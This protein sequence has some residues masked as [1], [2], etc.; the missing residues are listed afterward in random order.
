MGLACIT[1]P[2]SEPLTLEEAKD[3]L[4][5]DD[6]ITDDD[7]SIWPLVRRAR[8]WVENRTNRAL[9]RQTWRLSLRSFYDTR[10]ASIDR[11]TTTD[12]AVLFLASP[13]I[14][15]GQATIELRKSPL[16]LLD[17]SDQPDPAGDPDVTVTYLD[18]SGAWQTLS[19]SLYEVDPSEEPAIIAPAY[20]QVW[21]ATQP[22][23]V[24]VKIDFVCGYGGPALVPEPLKQATKML[25][26]ADYMDRLPTAA[27]MKTITNLCGNYVVTEFPGNVE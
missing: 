9:M 15:C 22:G 23:L 19:S 25:I 21:P 26:L 2:T 5:I 11:E 4:R 20:G 7:A 1:P 16:L 18:T 27:E 3:W 8:Q 6:D 13:G 14:V 10:A 12:P 17:D 24:A